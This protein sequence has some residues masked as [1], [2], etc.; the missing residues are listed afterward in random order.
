MG[1]ICLPEKRGFRLASPLTLTPTKRR[2]MNRITFY[3]L[4]C[5]SPRVDSLGFQFRPERVR[6]PKRVWGG[7]LQVQSG[8]MSK[9]RGS[10]SVPPCM[11]CTCG[12]GI[13]RVGASFDRG[14][15]MSEYHKFSWD[16]FYTRV[17]DGTYDSPVGR[18]F[19]HIN[20]ALVIT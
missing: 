3:R 14:C 17:M 8:L 19:T 5:S 9:S 6:L 20:H 11:D 16:Y 15:Y 4:K 13:C 7:F 1:D 10:L 18:Y 12:D 2:I